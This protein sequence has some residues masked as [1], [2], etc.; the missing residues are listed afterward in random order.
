MAHIRFIIIHKICYV[1]S[2][3]HKRSKYFQ[4][5]KKKMSDISFEPQ[6]SPGF[7]S[8]ILSLAWFYSSLRKMTWNMYWICNDE[9]SSVWSP[10][11]LIQVIM[12]KD[13][14]LMNM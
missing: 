4:D 1:K 2:Y 14:W 7:V 13:F 9:Q 8:M 11:E 12:G 3:F 5:K 6:S 10:S